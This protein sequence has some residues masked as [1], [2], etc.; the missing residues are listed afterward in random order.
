MARR[1]LEWWLSVLSLI[2]AAASL[3]LGAWAFPGDYRFAM[4]ASAC[5]GFALWL[6]I[7]LKP[8]R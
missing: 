1:E 5:I 6:V 3:L 2:T 4:V 7:G 8:G